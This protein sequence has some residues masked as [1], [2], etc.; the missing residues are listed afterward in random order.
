[1][2]GAIVWDSGI[3][4]GTATTVDTAPLINGS[5]VA[6]AQVWSTVGGVNEFP[7]AEVTKT[8][9]VN[10]QPVAG[11]TSINVV[12][13]PGTPLF[14]ITVGIPSGLGDYDDSLAYVEVQRTDC[15]GE[16]ST[17]GL[18]QV[19]S[20][21]LIEDFE[22]TVLAVTLIDSGDEPWARS[23]DNQHTGAY[24]L[25]S[26]VI[27]DNETSRVTIIIPSG[28]HT[29]H[30]WYSVSSEEGFDYL[31]MYVD[32]IEIDIDQFSGEIPWTRKTLDITGVTTIAFQYDK[33]VSVAR[34]SDAAWIDDFIFVGATAET[35]SF[36]DWTAPRA[37]TGPECDPDV[38]CEFQYRTRLV[39]LKDG[40]LVT[41]EWLY[42]MNVTAS[43]T[44][45]FTGNTAD[46]TIELGCNATPFTGVGLT[47]VIG[48]S[49]YPTDPYTHSPGIGNT[50][51]D[52]NIY[53]TGTVD[54]GAG[55]PLGTLLR[56][57][58]LAARGGSSTPR[59]FHMRTSVD[60]FTTDV[61]A[62]AL[63]TQRPMWTSYDF[64]L[65]VPVTGTGVEVRVYPYVA[66]A[67]QDVDFDEI[68]LT[69]GE[70]ITHTLEW[71]TSDV[72]LRTLDAS[73]PLWHSACGDVQWERVRPFTDELGVMGDQKVRSNVPGGRDYT[74]NLSVTTQEDVEA[75]ERIFA[76]QLVLVSPV[77]LPEQ[78]VGPVSQSVD[79]LK[80]KRARSTSIKTI[81][82]GPEPPHS[83]QEVIG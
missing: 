33:D 40:V 34:G 80:V 29:L 63:P 12:Q 43:V 36:V 2:G 66:G 72:L 42:E 81:G 30:F 10:V 46:P 18:E 74:L 25:R 78:W 65:N 50:S 47:Q 76:R 3:V 4:A 7:S 1:L 57:A 24:S 58:L 75:L 41:S 15:D 62:S 9:S 77:D 59:G 64:A 49:G 69:F 26:G 14:D 23:T 83:P 37:V 60:G 21:R 55:P 32:D 82:T 61:Y 56:V 31:R 35:A 19:A 68:T 6:H 39:G 73:G 54:A 5:Y 53:Y 38:P 51:L 16:W 71:P 13:R 52:P 17:I 20:D 45:S 48:S 27:T 11:P 22:D 79:V 70:I 8:F 28:Y 67:E 44:W